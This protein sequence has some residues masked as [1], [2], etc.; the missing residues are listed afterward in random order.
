MRGLSQHRG[1]SPD[2]LSAMPFEAGADVRR[3]GTIGRAGSLAIVLSIGCAVLIACPVERAFASDSAQANAVE[4]WQK[5][6][7]DVCSKTEDAM[8]FPVDELKSLVERCDR[9]EPQIQ[10]LDETRKRV[11]LRRLSQCRGLFAYVLEAKQ[12]DKK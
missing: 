7:D 4:P 1:F 8:T 2:G 3:A 9:L 6:F 5:E 11:Y 10:Q 12:K